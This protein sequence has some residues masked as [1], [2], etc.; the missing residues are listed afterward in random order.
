MAHGWFKMVRVPVPEWAP[1]YACGAVKFEMV[2]TKYN[3]AI[4]PT[5]RDAL[6]KRHA[7]IL[8]LTDTLV[9]EYVNEGRASPGEGGF[10]EH[11]RLTGEFYVGNESYHRLLGESWIQICIE[12]R[13]LGRE[14]GG[15]NDYLGLHVWLCYDPKNDRLWSH[16]NTDSMVI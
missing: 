11:N 8:A 7:D 2:S 4:T 14:S 5:E 9:E 15:S 16:R 6:M 13:C 1:P 3:D 12:A 10:P